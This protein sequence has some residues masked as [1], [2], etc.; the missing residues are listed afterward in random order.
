MCVPQLN[1]LSMKSFIGLE[2]ERRTKCWRQ[3]QTGLPV[4]TVVDPTHLLAGLKQVQDSCSTHGLLLHLGVATSEFR[5]GLSVDVQSLFVGGVRGLFSNMVGRSEADRREESSMQ[6][7]L[8]MPFS[9]NL[10]PLLNIMLTQEK[11]QL[12]SPVGSTWAELEKRTESL[13][14]KSDTDE[15]SGIDRK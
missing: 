3:R 5:L 4:G 11:T 10:N 1:R 6:D 12:W 8:L 2:G 9:Q 15:E 13:S 7:L 14:W